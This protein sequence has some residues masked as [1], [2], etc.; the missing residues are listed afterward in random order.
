LLPIRILGEAELL[1]SGVFDG[2]TV[3]CSLASVVGKECR[4]SSRLANGTLRR[5]N[6]S[7]G[8]KQIDRGGE[9]SLRGVGGTSRSDM[10][11]ER[12]EHITRGKGT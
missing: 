10:G 2:T 11:D 8:I 9:G 1:E 6:G 4:E 5:G 3:F 12:Q 7:D